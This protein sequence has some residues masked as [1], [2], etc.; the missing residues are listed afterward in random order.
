MSSK[1]PVGVA[2]AHDGL[3]YT[4]KRLQ[5]SPAVEA[6]HVGDDGVCPWQATLVCV[7]K[8]IAPRQQSSFDR[9]KEHAL[10]TYKNVLRIVSTAYRRVW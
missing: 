10:K 2:V 5:H 9:H 4:D 6:M 7:S 1:A 8:H 3:L